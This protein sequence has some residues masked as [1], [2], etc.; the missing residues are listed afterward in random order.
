ME[1]RKSGRRRASPS[2]TAQTFFLINGDDPWHVEG[3]SSSCRVFV[4]ILVL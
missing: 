4:V 3:S 1:I 2:L